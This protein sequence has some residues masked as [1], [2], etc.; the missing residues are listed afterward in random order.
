MRKQQVIGMDYESKAAIG[1]QVLDA[2]QS[3]KLRVVSETYTQ[4]INLGNGHVVDGGTTIVI[5]IDGGDLG[6]SFQ[7]AE[8]NCCGG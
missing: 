6:V 8:E 3:A 7:V 1:Q 4:S 5:Q 2:L